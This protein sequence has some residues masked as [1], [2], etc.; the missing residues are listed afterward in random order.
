MV[1]GVLEMFVATTCLKSHSALL[2]NQELNLFIIKQCE[3]A[4]DKWC[5]V[6]FDQLAAINMVFFSYSHKEKHN[7]LN[8]A[9]CVTRLAPALIGLSL[10][11]S[12]NCAFHVPRH[13][14]DPDGGPLR[15][16]FN[17][18]LVDTVGFFLAHVTLAKGST[19]NLCT[20]K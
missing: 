14:L 6:P 16:P 8:D 11:L 9:Q 20:Q 13:P 12:P 3:K 5:K 18:R 4:A 1:Q 19:N 15:P 2:M 7:R 17:T 10:H